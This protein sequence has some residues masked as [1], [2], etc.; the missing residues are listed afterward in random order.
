MIKIHTCIFYSTLQEDSSPSHSYGY[1]EKISRGRISSSVLQETMA[2]L[3]DNTFIL[4]CGTRSFEQ[5]M[6]ENM[7][8]LDIPPSKYHKF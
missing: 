7:K 5:D 1:D 2:D 6:I 3:R 4:I 8:L